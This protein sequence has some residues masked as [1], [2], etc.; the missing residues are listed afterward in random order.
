MLKYL[1]KRLAMMVAVLLILL[2]FLSSLV[3]LVPGDPVDVMIGPM[4]GDDF[5]QTVR[6][7][8]GLDRPV[9]VQVTDFVIAAIRG[10]LGDDFVSNR[11]VTEMI[12]AVLP[13]TMLLAV[14]GLGLAVVI[15][16]P[17]GVYAAIHANGPADRLIAAASIVFVTLPP[18]VTG[19]LFLLL[20]AVSLRWL[21]ALGAGSLDDPLDFLARLILPASALAL[22]W[23]GYLARLTRASMLEVLNADYLRTARSLGLHDARVNYVYALRT[24]V[25]PVVAVLGVGLGHLL[26]GA[27]FIEVIFS[28][29][30]LGSLFYD[31][32]ATRN[33]PV[34]RG[35]A[36]VVAGI[37]V[38]TNLLADLSYRLLDPRIRVE[39]AQ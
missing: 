1:G 36:V 29:P 24:A 27:I 18:Y 39:E 20:F 9:A 12:G 33:F 38:L 11:P 25:I 13:H 16:L 8:M 21:P 35:I 15:G 37:F 30:G 3:H 14:A 28:R 19:L 2:V 4:A 10:D 5:R 32:I 26:G 6:E 7:E 22:S 31:S 23:I 17:L 34:I